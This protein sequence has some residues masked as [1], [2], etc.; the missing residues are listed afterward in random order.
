M[1]RGTAFLVQYIFFVL[2]VFNLIEKNQPH[3]TNS[4]EK[5]YIC[6]LEIT[7]FFHLWNYKLF[8][9]KFTKYADSE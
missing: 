2:N 3:I 7:N 9:I 8:R 1:V 6:N 5:T 4:I